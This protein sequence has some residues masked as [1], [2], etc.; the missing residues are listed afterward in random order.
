[1]AV[2]LIVMLVPTYLVSRTAGV[3]AANRDRSGATR[4]ATITFTQGHCDYRGKLVDLKSELLFVYNLAKVTGPISPDKPCPIEPLAE[5]K[6]PP[7]WLIRSDAVSDA[8]IIHY[9]QE[10]IP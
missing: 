1:M 7:L 4:L 9:A 5:S 2:A 3:Q 10:A 6:V 8:R